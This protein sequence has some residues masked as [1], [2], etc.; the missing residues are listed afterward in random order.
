MVVQ[1]ASGDVCLGYKCAEDGGG[2]DHE[3]MGAVWT[4]VES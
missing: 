2:R 1:L 3:N 4:N